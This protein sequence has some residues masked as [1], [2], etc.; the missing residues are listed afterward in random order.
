MISLIQ[1]CDQGVFEMRSSPVEI[2]FNAMLRSEMVER[3]ARARV[4][5]LA[6]EFPSVLHWRVLLEQPRMMDPSQCTF[7]ARVYARTAHGDMACAHSSGPELPAAL[8]MAL[9][10]IRVHL[11]DDAISPSRPAWR[12]APAAGVAAS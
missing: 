3:M 11:T 6:G 7:G 8:E 4:D 2:Q 10:A 5:Q 9:A 12:A 1:M